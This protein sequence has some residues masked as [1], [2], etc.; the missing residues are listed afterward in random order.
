MK[1]RAFYFLF[2]MFGFI[3]VVF[4]LVGRGS[5]WLGARSTQ[6]SEWAGYRASL[7]DA[8]LF[9]MKDPRDGS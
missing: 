6:V 9:P 7:L 2:L 5:K 8:T 1:A 4:D 3:G